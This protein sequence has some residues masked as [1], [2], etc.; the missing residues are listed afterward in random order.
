M[1]LSGRSRRAVRRNCASARRATAEQTQSDTQ[2]RTIVWRQRCIRT[3]SAMNMARASLF[4]LF[5]LIVAATAASAGDDEREMIKTR[6]K[7][8]AEQA[9]VHARAT[10]F[11]FDRSHGAMQNWTSETV[12]AYARKLGL[13]DA[14]IEAALT[15]HQVDG[16]GLL[17]L[18]DARNE[19][20]VRALGDAI[21]EIQR[22]R[23]KALVLDPTHAV[24]D[25][26]MVREDSF[27]HYRARNRLLVSTWAPVVVAS[28]R[29][30]LFVMSKW[31]PELY[32]DLQ[33]FHY[34]NRD[35]NATSDSLELGFSDVWLNFVP[36]TR[37]LLRVF[38][39]TNPFV[40]N[41]AIFSMVTAF[42]AELALF[43][44]TVICAF[45]RRYRAQT[46]L[47]PQSTRVV[48]MTVDQCVGSVVLFVYGFA[49]L[50]GAISF[51][52]HSMWS[53]IPSIVVDVAFHGFLVLNYALGCLNVF[54]AIKF[55]SL[56][57][58]SFAASLA[59]VERAG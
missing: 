13:H 15:A 41:G 18:I 45:S 22:L 50:T 55:V 21:G 46:R 58:R 9:I 5:I 42:L 59:P 24:L 30:F 54:I 56:T 6:T 38:A 20:A 11:A 19:H 8:T 28:P 2:Q 16:V 1:F 53:L 32:H 26:D 17:A 43:A 27:W 37:S 12:V 23:F 44:H 40:C 48:S 3:Q 29:V 31:Y 14:S 33:A 39:D 52:T 36:A 7:R 10:F 57:M 47:L 51:I 4:L 49:V 25:D 34:P 35:V